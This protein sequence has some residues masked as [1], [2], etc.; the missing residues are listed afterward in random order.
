ML[1]LAVPSTVVCAAKQLAGEQERSCGP[2]RVEQNAQRVAFYLER[3]FGND[4]GN[5]PC[6]YH[7]LSCE[8]DISGSLEESYFKL[9]YIPAAVID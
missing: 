9:P 3:C 4:A 1:E 7:R 2:K 8:V 5:L 6:D